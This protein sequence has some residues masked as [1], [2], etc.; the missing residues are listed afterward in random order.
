LMTGYQLCRVVRLPNG[1]QL[2]FVQLADKEASTE[3]WLI[4]CNLM[5]ERLWN[6]KLA[7]VWNDERRCNESDRKEQFDDEEWKH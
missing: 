4:W 5:T 3:T 6:P 7:S 1:Q 2:G